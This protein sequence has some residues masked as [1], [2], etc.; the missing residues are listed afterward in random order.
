MSD[1]KFSHKHLSLVELL[2]NPDHKHNITL[3]IF[4]NTIYDPKDTSDDVVN[5][6]GLLN[7]NYSFGK[8]IITIKLTV[9][10]DYWL[11]KDRIMSIRMVDN[12]LKVTS[13]MIARNISDFDFDDLDKLIDFSAIEKRYFAKEHPNTVLES[14]VVGCKCLASNMSRPVFRQFPKKNYGCYFYPTYD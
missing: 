9:V 7:F 2:T 10:L 6:Y 12:D 5:C 8:S 3:S 14:L 13:Q 11:E 4:E 1:N